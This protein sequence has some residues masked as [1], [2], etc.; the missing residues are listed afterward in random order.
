M[1]FSY[2]LQFNTVPEW[3][4][5]YLSYGQLKK[6]IHDIQSARAE[7]AKTAAGGS[8]V[9]APQGASSLEMGPRSSLL[10]GE[11]FR[12]FQE[13]AQRVASAFTAKK[14]ASNAKF[15]EFLDSVS[16]KSESSSNLSDVSVNKIK[17]WTGDEDSLEKRR[18]SLEDS[19]NAVYLNL[20]DLHDFL[21]LNYT[22]YVRVV[23]NYG[24]YVQAT[25]EVKR[26][27]LS[28]I[29]YILPIAELSELQ[30][31]MGQVEDV[32]ARVM[33]DGSITQARAA[34]HLLLRDRLASLRQNGIPASPAES[35]EIVKSAPVH[36]V[37]DSKT[38]AVAAPAVIQ[39]A[40]PAAAP[41]PKASAPYFTTYR[42]AS[43]ISISLV[44]LGILLAPEGTFGEK[45]TGAKQRCLAI[46]VSCV[47]LWIT[48]GIPLYI[49]ALLIPALTVVL[50]AIDKEHLQHKGFSLDNAGEVSKFVFGSIFSDMIFLLLGGFSIAA[51]F[52]K[53]GITKTAAVFILKRLGKTPASTLL[54]VMVITVVASAFVSNVAAPVL[55]FGLIQ[56][57]LKNLEFDHPFARA[58]ILGIAF[59]ANIGGLASPIASPQSVFGANQLKAF[60]SFAS[61]IMLAL[62]V[63]IV[64]T[65]FCWFWLL[66]AYPSRETLNFKEIFSAKADEKSVS[67]GKIIYILAVFA[68]TIVMWVAAPA[69]EV[70]AGPMGITAVFPLVAYFGA[71]LLGKDDFNGFSWN[72]VILAVGGSALGKSLQYSKLLDAIGEIIGAYL[73]G[74]SYLAVMAIFCTILL[75]ITTFV[76]HSVGA[77]V[78]IPI[79]IK[80][81]QSAGMEDPVVACLALAACF[82]CSAGMAMPIS[83]FPNMTA[84]SLQDRKGRNYV[85]TAEF[86]KGGIVPSII[87]A[88]SIVGSVALLGGWAVNKDGSFTSGGH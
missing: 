59:G 44:F 22:G 18:A 26:E 49:T 27:L 1:K 32:Y 10:E 19:F 7:E 70:V 43:L 24:K 67:A 68:M 12:L 63:C 33:C 46:L 8:A 15:E 30:N 62:P 80:F 60:F 74:F 35:S 83:G 21:D 16:A 84:A 14:L 11:F 36:Y 57:I 47:A 81:A 2:S 51:V 85:S 86:S 88:A 31:K 4:E 87:F 61:W 37:S 25:A 64:S 69:L 9:K 40:P 20:H 75:V 55:C 77:F 76:S 39:E 82:T 17:V 53:Y 45:I 71:G 5:D 58:L 79:I 50:Q 48:E 73:G 38:Q 29:D 72:V 41:A 3:T 28:K 23:K 52:Q 54:T 66:K 34:L 6:A 65:L 78:F 42:I 56:P 13:D